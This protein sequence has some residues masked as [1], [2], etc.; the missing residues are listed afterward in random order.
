M[1]SISKEIN[2]GKFKISNKSKSLIVAELSGNHTGKISN[3]F[4]AIDAIAKSG[5]DAIKIQSYEPDTITLNSKNK[6][7]Y[8]NELIIK[9]LIMYNR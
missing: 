8:I 3:V 4:K 1:K 5:A 2:I 6:Y 7:F 9:Y